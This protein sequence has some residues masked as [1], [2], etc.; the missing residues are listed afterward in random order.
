MIYFECSQTIIPTVGVPVLKQIEN[1]FLLITNPCNILPLLL[2]L[3]IEN[4]TC[5]IFTRNK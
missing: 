3:N 4:I 1:E 5:F 2:S